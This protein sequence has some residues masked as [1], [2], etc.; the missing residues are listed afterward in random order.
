MVFLWTISYSYNNVISVFEGIK[1][2]DINTCNFDGGMREK[3]VDMRE[4]KVKILFFI[5]ILKDV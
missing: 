5:V 3:D 4:G 1:V 2:G